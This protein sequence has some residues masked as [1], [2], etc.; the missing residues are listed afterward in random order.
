VAGA[1]ALELP[2]ARLREAVESAVGRA[3]RRSR[4]APAPASTD[5]GVMNPADAAP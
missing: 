1:E 3:L 2:F 4:G 5:N